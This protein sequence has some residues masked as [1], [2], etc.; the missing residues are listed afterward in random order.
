MRTVTLRA[1]RKKEEHW[2]PLTYNVDNNEQERRYITLSRAEITCARPSAPSGKCKTKQTSP[3]RRGS[4]LPTSNKP[5][6]RTYRAVIRCGGDPFVAWDPSQYHSSTIRG[7]NA[8]QRF[9]TFS[10]VLVRT[11]VFRRLLCQLR[12]EPAQCGVITIGITSGVM[13]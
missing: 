13:C 9:G 7:T 12:V 11:F 5:S 10:L 1:L 6:G 2:S 3:A 8:T 4:C